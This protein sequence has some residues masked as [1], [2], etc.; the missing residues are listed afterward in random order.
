MIVPPLNRKLLAILALDMVGYSK[1]TEIDEAGTIGRLRAIRADVTDTAIALHQGRIVKLL[2]D[3]ALVVFDS[4][5]DAVICAAEIQ[6]AVAVRN[7]GLPEQER[8]VFRI[9]INL[10]DVALVDGDVYGDG[11]NIA[12]R[13]EQLAEPGGVMVSGTAYDHL[14]GK[15]DWPLDFVGEQHVKNIN[16]PVRM[17]RVRLDG[18]RL[19]RTL[20]QAMPHWT[21]TAAAAIVVLALAGGGTWW[22][23][24]PA[25]LGAK[26]SVAVLPFNNYGDGASGRLADGLTE[27]IITDLAR[28]PELDV[29]ARNSTE[30]YKG[31]PV[32]ARQV[33]SALHVGFVLEGSIQRQDGR[34]RVTAQLIDALTGNHLWSDRWDRPAEDVF[35]VQTEIAEQ[36]SNRL[37][38][39]VGLIQTAGRA[40]A[41]RKR[42]ENLNAYDYYL[43]GTEKIEEITIA[44]EEE[45]IALLNR[46]VEL[47]PGLARA[48]VELYHAHGI[49]A[50]FG[51]N[52]ESEIKAAADVAERAVRLDPS[53]AEAHAVFGMSLSHKGDNARAKVEL[54][55]ALRLA[56]GSSEILTF[57][58]GYAARFGEPERGAQ[59][60]DQVM[61]L[62][63]N[64]PMWTSNFFGPAY[65]MAGRYE[66][67]LKMLV[68]MTP[69]NYDQWRWVVFGSTLAALGRMDEANAAVRD[70]LTQYPDLTVESMINQ[71][72]LS[73]KER[74]RFIET[75]PLAGFPACAKPEALAKLAKP[76]RL[77]ECEAGEAQ[78]LG[79]P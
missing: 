19:R 40:A 1:A 63:P 45:A 49:L 3:G 53:D 55:T 28:F 20:R 14:Q 59:M 21:R 35:A 11:V 64:Y 65:F 22:F 76:V 50:G 75:M 13:I 73:A 54:D 43:L 17:Y 61:R 33:A 44:D 78:P 51:I 60:V 70:T 12:A 8:I 30:V 26:P 56:P 7:G 29:V 41:K 69:N 36:V 9:G 79:Q 66:D 6:E 18:K 34:V 31:K 62:D 72:G 25:S 10:G 37:G 4:V 71:V 77:P 74:S 48:W 39:G 15:L 5:V 16:R 38:G 24:Q 46:A 42:P 2:G 52:P 27:D 23:F 68:R 67:A 32:D 57:Y 58:T 47:D